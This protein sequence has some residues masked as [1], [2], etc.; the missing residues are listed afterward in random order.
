MKSL[1]FNRVHKNGWVSFKLQGVPGAV[2]IDKRM[3]VEGQIP[4][5]GSTIELNVAGLQEPGASATE[6]DAAKAAEKLAKETAKAEKSKLAAEKAQARLAKLQE[7]ATKAAQ[8]VE[9]AKA[10]ANAPATETTGDVANL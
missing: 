10:R 6:A 7:N 4:A 2:Y 8:A 3:F 5:A 9:A 1:T